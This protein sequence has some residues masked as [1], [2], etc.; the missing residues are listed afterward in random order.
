MS[1]TEYSADGPA[2][3][4]ILINRYLDAYRAG[5]AP[6]ISDFAA[7]YPE[8]REEL[9]ELLPIILEVEQC[10][11]P[12]T[13]GRYPGLLPDL[14]MELDGEFRLS[15]LIGCG[16]M[17]A[18]YE[19]EQLS[20]KRRCA[21]KLLTNS[22]TLDEAGRRRFARESELIAHLHH[23][24]IIAVHSA[25]TCNGFSYYAMDL[26]E[27]PPLASFCTSPEAVARIGLQV[28]QALAYAHGYGIVHC[29][30]KP[31]NILT[32]VNGTVRL[33]DFGL[34]RTL[35]E[36]EGDSGGTLRYMPPER[37]RREP[38]SAAADQ[39]SLGMTLRELLGDTFPGDQSS[40]DIRTTILSGT[41]PPL[42]HCPPDLAAVIG[43]LTAAAPSD[44]YT[45]MQ[46]AVSELTA[47]IEHR[48][49]A[50]RPAALPRRLWMLARRRPATAAGYTLAL[51][52]ASG[53]AAA[54]AIGYA[55]TAE[56]RLRAE[57]SAAVANRTLIRVLTHTDTALPSKAG[58]RLL[59][60]LL[61]YYSDLANRRALPESTLRE[62]Y[63]A[64]GTA[65]KRSGLL[66]LAETTFGQLRQIAP[67]ATVGCSY[68]EV[69]YGQGKTL[70]ARAADEATV[71]HFSS[72]P[73]PTDRLGA[74]TALLRLGP[75]D[76]AEQQAAARLIASLATAIPT[77]PGFRLQLA[78]ALLL[79]PKTVPPELR[80]RPKETDIANALM[81]M[82][83]LIRSEAS[84]AYGTALI[85]YATRYLM[86]LPP[87]AEPDSD[88][89]IAAL[90]ESGRMLG[91]WF[92]DSEVANAVTRFWGAVA[93]RL[94][95]SGNERGLQD[96][97]DRLYGVLDVLFYSTET[98][99]ETRILLLRLLLDR[100]KQACDS[101]NARDIYIRKTLL[102]TKLN[103]LH[104]PA[105]ADIRRQAATLLR[106]HPFTF[107][108]HGNAL[109]REID[110]NVEC[111][112]F[113]PTAVLPRGLSSRR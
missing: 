100:L 108:K 14:P 17:G 76:P 107:G 28:A 98:P 54:L 49:V 7:R 34:S 69:L 102:E 73:D 96:F 41:L 60:D 25:G 19:A 56:A 83:E 88:F 104:T 6:S 74:L 62:A 91:R 5:T 3:A 37:L 77:H 47:F 92:G 44:R 93:H 16:G 85:H 43:R 61:P 101:K 1:P 79:C 64:I 10:E 89:T 2:Q 71:R 45:S 23:P 53:A 26:I 99:E 78:N 95:T 33:G 12:D 32:E 67:S 18:V 113:V 46:L 66:P 13:P 4:D 36:T 109:S 57:H 30:V 42:K 63:A 55:T 81:I 52:C 86:R 8:V 39:Y 21:V 9:E 90:A 35:S 59:N 106:D 80:P 27:G 94:R 112:F 82:Q 84:P 31:S 22:R 11:P 70:Q 111:S 110:M 40:A 58:T 50:A 15:R 38:F 20:L 68:A 48:P 65:A 103:L 72:S 75:E 29:D 97:T 24:N 105:A 51:L 87:D